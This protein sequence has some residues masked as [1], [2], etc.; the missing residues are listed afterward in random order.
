MMRESAACQETPPLPFFPFS[1]LA[2]WVDRPDSDIVQVLTAASTPSPPSTRPPTREAEKSRTLALLALKSSMSS[3]RHDCHIAIADPPR[4]P[5]STSK[6]TTRSTTSELGQP[7][8][9]APRWRGGE[10]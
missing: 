10:R 4:V 2:R 3:G 5:V 1:F 7:G 9:W 8:D 6:E